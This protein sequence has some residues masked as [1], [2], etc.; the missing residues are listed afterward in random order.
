MLTRELA[1]AAYDAGRILPDRLLSQETD[2]AVRRDIL[3]NQIDDA[4]ATVMRQAYFVLFEREAHDL[5]RN[6]ATTDALAERSLE[7]LREQFG[8]GGELGEASKPK[9]LK[10]LSYGGSE[11][12]A[13]ILAEAGIDI[14][15]P[16]FWQGGFDVI[17]DVIDE[18][19]RLET[20]KA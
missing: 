6:G 1:I 12:P 20:V 5:I 8:E 16:E 15:S 10:R 11:S 2:V 13:R 3:A 7:H 19:Q 18:L 4:Y 17:K 9:Y 14:A